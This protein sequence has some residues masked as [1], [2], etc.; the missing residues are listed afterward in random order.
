M[1]KSMPDIGLVLCGGGG[2]GAYQI[3][4]W[5]ALR[6][7]GLDRRITAVSGTS[8]GALNA[9]LF[10]CGDLALAEK[11]WT[12]LRQQD[13]ADPVETA[14]RVITKVLDFLGSE[15]KTITLP[16]PEKAARA[17]LFSRNGLISLIET[18]GVNKCVS[19]C[20]MPCFACCHNSTLGIPE[21]FDMSA[22]TPDEITEFLTASTAIPAVF[23]AKEIGGHSYRDGGLSDNTPIKP[24]Y[25][26]GIRQFIIS[27]L[28]SGGADLSQFPDAEFLE[29]FP[30]DEILLG[31]PEKRLLK[32]GTLDFDGENAALRI[33]LGRQE[34]IMQLERSSGAFFQP[35]LIQNSLS[36]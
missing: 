32:T 15:N 11:I 7:R 34:T 28:G 5:K 35:I 22:L 12:S 18:N 10:A 27:Y 19:G 6:E 16:D 1:M 21:Y 14:G 31:K 26:I 36:K 25:D 13:I 30:S 33:E 9:A 4:V 23:P 2:R 20:G 29:L 3:G 8:V 24:L 17:G